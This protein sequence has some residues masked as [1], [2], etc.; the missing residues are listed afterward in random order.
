MLSAV[1]PAER[2]GAG[3]RTSISRADDHADRPRRRHRPR[4]RPTC[5]RGVCRTECGGLAG[6]PM[7]RCGLQRGANPR[8][9]L[10]RDV[11]C[12]GV[13][14]AEV[15]QVTADPVEC[16]QHLRG[17]GVGANP[18][19]QRRRGGVVEQARLQ[20]GQQLGRDRFAPARGPRRRP[21]LP[22]PVVPRPDASQSPPRRVRRPRGRHGSTN[23]SLSR[24]AAAAAPALKYSSASASLARAREQRLFTVPSA[25]PSMRAVS[26]TE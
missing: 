16:R 8:G 17:V 15:G 13:V 24:S 3:S 18:L 5:H 23:H 25:M 1:G 9:H 21:S 19:A 6:R 12:G 2:V 26:A 22:P 10:G 4:A 11:G 20:V 7:R 14:G